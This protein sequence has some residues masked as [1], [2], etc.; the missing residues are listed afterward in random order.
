MSLTKWADIRGYLAHVPNEGGQS[1][2][3]AAEA[4]ETPRHP[5]AE[6]V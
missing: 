4:L 5:P 2:S 1:S 3:A 6:T